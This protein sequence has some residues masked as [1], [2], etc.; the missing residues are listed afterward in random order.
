MERS[1]LSPVNYG[2]AAKLPRGLLDG[3][4]LQ[5]EL[6]SRYASFLDIGR[7]FKRKRSSNK[8]LMALNKNTKSLK[9][10]RMNA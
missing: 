6:R 3:N 5:S 2:I 4:E 9:A 8:E 1:I 7:I 10:W